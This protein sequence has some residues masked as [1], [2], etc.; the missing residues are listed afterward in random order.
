[1]YKTIHKNI[2]LTLIVMFLLLGGLSPVMAQTSG[3]YKFNSQSGL[4]LTAFVS[5]YETGAITATPLETVIGRSITILLSLVG[6][7]FL[8]LII[9]GSFTWMTAG[10]NEEKVKKAMSTI[11]S[12]LIGLI[13]T[14]SAYVIS[15]FLIK[16]FM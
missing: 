13:I 7:I 10:G 12:S 16:F 15:Y 11:M 1:M 4:N 6:V 3:T 9:F 5:G 2:I 14:L 8:I